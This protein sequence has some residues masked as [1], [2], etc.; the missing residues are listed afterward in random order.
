MLH[1]T[2]LYVEMSTL[3]LYREDLISEM[4]YFQWTARKIATF[5]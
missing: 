4:F 5:I 3:G 1:I 2:F